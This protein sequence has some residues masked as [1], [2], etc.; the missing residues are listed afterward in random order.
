[1]GLTQDEVA[2][3]TVEDNQP[4]PPREPAKPPPLPED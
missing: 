3:F 2:T 4:A 1:M